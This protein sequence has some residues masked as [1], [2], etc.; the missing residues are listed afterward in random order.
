[1]RKMAGTAQK[2]GNRVCNETGMDT[3]SAGAVLACYQE[4]RG[5]R[6]SPKEI[7]ALLLEFGLARTRVLAGGHRRLKRIQ[8][9]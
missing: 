8:R 5:K 9:L 7:P 1:M 4:G 2:G 6:L 3:L